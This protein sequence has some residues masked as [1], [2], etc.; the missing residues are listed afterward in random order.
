MENFREVLTFL[1][2]SSSFLEKLHKLLNWSGNNQQRIAF[3][4]VSWIS[5]N[6][7]IINADR[8]S[9]LL[10]VKPDTIFSTLRNHG[11]TRQVS[12]N[13]LQKIFFRN[14][15]T[16][17]GISIETP[18]KAKNASNKEESDINKGKMYKTGIIEFDDLISKLFMSFDVI[19]K[20]DLIKEFY[21]QF[22]PNFVKF[23]NMEWIFSDY[24]QNDVIEFEEFFTFY[25]HFG[26]LKS[27]LAKYSLYKKATSNPTVNIP[28][29]HTQKIHIGEK[30]KFLLNNKYL[31]YNDYKA[32]IGKSFLQTENKM[33]FYSW[34]NIFEC[35]PSIKDVQKVRHCVEDTAYQS[36][37]CL[38][39]E[40]S[41]S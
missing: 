20:N 35:L 5:E 16:I 15:F 2:K 27:I 1:N 38:Q 9:Q 3:S 12:P 13:N 39:N 37:H 30:N 29:I 41:L 40:I 8:L 32:D 4:G 28:Q 10:I 26:P 24:F 21:S 34:E 31:I 11:F 23:E 22:C 25:Q 19:S 33:A 36:E 14:G 6:S 18:V 7:F 17:N